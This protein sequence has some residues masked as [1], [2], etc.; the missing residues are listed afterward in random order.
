MFTV[1]GVTIVVYFI[2][3]PSGSRK[4]NLYTIYISR[5][6]TQV[7]A[8]PHRGFLTYGFFKVYTVKT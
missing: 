1:F 2:K 3:I 8:P 4:L 5:L 6:E 7:A